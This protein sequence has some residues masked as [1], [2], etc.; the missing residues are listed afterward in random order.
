M[1]IPKK[2]SKKKLINFFI[3]IGLKDLVRLNYKFNNKKYIDERR[4]N[5]PQPPDLNDL[6]YLYQLIILNKRTTVLEF[7]CGFSTL[8]MH[9]ALKENERRYGAKKPFERCEFPYQLFSV[10]N[11]KKYIKVAKKRVTKY[12]QNKSKVNFFYSKAR[13][14]LFNNN[15][16]VEYDKLPKVN[17]DFIYLDAPSQWRV[18]GSINNFTTAHSDMMPMSC[19]IIKF[20]NFL[21]PG[22]I[23]VSDGRIANSIFLKNN[24]KRNWIFKIDKEKDQC[25]FYLN[26]PCLG[27]HNKK[28]LEFYKKK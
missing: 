20:E 18:E 24:F 4:Q 22:T 21:T 2:I 13:M 6:Y 3:K 16:A 28:Q 8:V 10:D 5:S 25:F 12:S 14:T 1:K 11:Q 23:I 7:G 15:F 17:P 27:P 9:M 26:D 19:D